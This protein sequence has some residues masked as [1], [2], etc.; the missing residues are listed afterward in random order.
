MKVV[1]TEEMINEIGQF[2]RTWRFACGCEAEGVS[3][4]HQSAG[5]SGIRLIPCLVHTLEDEPVIEFLW[6]EN[7]LDYFEQI[8]GEPV[9]LEY[10]RHS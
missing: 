5:W 7:L 1:V 6:P 4:N 8:S 2:R 9:E 3:S 10:A